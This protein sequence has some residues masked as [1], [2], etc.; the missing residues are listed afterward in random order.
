[1]QC[2]PCEPED[3][4]QQPQQHTV[5]GDCDVGAR[6]TCARCRVRI[7]QSGVGATGADATGAD[8][9]GVDA[10]PEATG[11]L[12]ELER[13][14]STLMSNGVYTEFDKHAKAVQTALEKRRERLQFASN[15]YEE[16]VEDAMVDT[17]DVDAG[18]GVWKE[19]D[20]YQGDVNLRTLNALL[21]RVD[22]RGFER[23]PHQLEFHAAFFEACSRIIFKDD[24]E[25]SKPQIC[26]KYG[27]EEVKSEVMISTPRRFGKTYRHAARVPVGTSRLPTQTPFALRVR[28]IAIFCAC[29]SLA[30][31]L[32]IV[33]FSPARRASRKLLERIVE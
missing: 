18:L 24:W 19:G 26:R 2:Q 11:E 17:E 4:A 22:Q 30:F 12:P 25:V 9:T 16:L 6:R 14:F 7:F 29:L 31:G 33:V 28:S 23:S 32:E 3:E 5:C 13:A 10:E 27:W 21:E 15:T 8:A 1:M 20:I